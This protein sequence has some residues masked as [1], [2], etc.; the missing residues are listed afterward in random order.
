[1]KNFCIPVTLAEKLKEGAKRGEIDIEK[2]YAMTSL[3]R[4]AVFEKYV[5][6]TI[7]K[8]INLGFEKA[9]TSSKVTA[10]KDWAEN[11]FTG[12]DKLPMK[13]GVLSKIQELS[14]SGLLTPEKETAF[15]QDLVA[16]KLG[17]TVT[18]EEATKINEL[19]TKLDKLSTQESEFGTPTAEYFKA[20]REMQDYIESITPSNQIKV[21]S[22]IIGRGNM[23][24]R[25]SSP[26][27]N[28]ESNTVMAGI[29]ALSRRLE[30]KQVGGAN[31]KYASDY[32]KFA[33]KLY[34]DTGYDVTRMQTIDDDFTVKGED[35]LTSQGK[36]KIR[37]VARI[38]EDVI[39]KG[40]QGL[41]DVVFSSF[42]SAD[43]ANIESTKLAQQEGL[44]GAEAKD[45]ALEIF[46]DSTRVDPKTKEGKI[47]RDQAIADAMYSTYTNKSLASDISLGIRKV[48]NLASGNLRIG[49]QI[50]PFVKTPANVISTGLNMSGIGLPVDA[51]YRVF[52]TLK[53][54][55]D[56]EEWN[57][58]FKEEF[59]GFSKTVIQAGLGITF[60]FILASLFDPEDYIGEYPTSEK[61]RQLLALRNATTNSVKI[62]DKWV[63][64]DYFGPLGSPMTGLLYAKKYGNTLPEKSYQYFKGVLAQT[65]KLPGFENTKD[66]VDYLNGLSDKGTKDINDEIRDVMNYVIGFG[67]SRL[68]PGILSDIAKATDTVER[69]TTGDGDMFARVKSVLPGF[70]QTLPTKQTVYGE[71]IATELAWSAIL[72]GSRVKTSKDNKI[73]EELL[74]LDKTNNLP[75]ITDVSKTSPRAKELKEQIGPEKFEEFMTDFG[76]RMAEETSKE[77]GKSGYRR[78]IDEDKKKRLDKIKN[79]LF[80]KMLKKYRYKKPKK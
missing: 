66:I 21:L 74:R 22:S 5:D 37:K 10:L 25:I 48:F 4:R 64:L 12:S 31:T 79:D 35:I 39:F 71:D 23:L 52:K 3:E 61:E 47:I 44:K 43:R 73:T 8:E 63:S 49:D 7:A 6:K 55:K 1:M 62:G 13:K 45:R 41:P 30:T 27:L 11:T 65:A 20:R 36:G 29:Q 67:Q 9:M 33:I 76:R 70:R 34:K 17:L 77:L 14:E 58:A 26:F 59:A 60:A 24:A 46:K 54:I 32:A 72:F 28:I 75:S 78:A 51:T 69:K 53:S 38:Y 40:M 15:Y 16:E 57:D 2:M 19:S 56:G 50:M 68:V 42:A 18:T 80:E